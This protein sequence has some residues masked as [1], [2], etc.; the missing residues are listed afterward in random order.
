MEGDEDRINDKFYV[1]SLSGGKL[2]EDK[3]A[4][5]VK[6]LDVLLRSK[7]TGT[8]ATRPKFE[9]TAATGGTGKARLYTLMGEWVAGVSGIQS[10]NRNCCRRPRDAV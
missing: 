9:N 7:P 4:D 10:Q 6:A 1:R 2:S 3:A 5:C 8:E